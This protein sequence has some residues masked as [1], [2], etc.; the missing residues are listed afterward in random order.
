MTFEVSMIENIKNA[1]IW[2]VL[3]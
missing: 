2:D 1:L 3:L